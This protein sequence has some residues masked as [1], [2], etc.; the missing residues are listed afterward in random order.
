[1]D[2]H[3]IEYTLGNY[4]FHISTANNVYSSAKRSYNLHLRDKLKESGNG[5]SLKWWKTLKSSLFGADVSLPP[6]F[7]PD[8]SVT[9]DPAENASLF[10]AYSNENQ[11]YFV[12]FMLQI[13]VTHNQF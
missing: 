8:G 9:H 4:G 5:N 7:K 10:A 1:M 3:S 11:T 12:I 13:R 2:S 6:I